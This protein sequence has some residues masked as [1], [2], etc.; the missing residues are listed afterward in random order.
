MSVINLWP[1]LAPFRKAGRGA[2]MTSYDN[3]FVPIADGWIARLQLNL[4]LLI[5][6]CVRYL[7]IQLS[8]WSSQW[9]LPYFS[10][11][12]IL[13]KLFNFTTEMFLT[14]RIFVFVDWDVLDLHCQNFYPPQWRRE[15]P[16]RFFFQMKQSTNIHDLGVLAFLTI[17][18]TVFRG[19][20]RYSIFQLHNLCI[21]C[22]TVCSLCKLAVL[23]KCSPF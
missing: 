12:Q 11:M 5:G 16:S 9:Q 7:H 1:I 21:S 15:H 2:W 3:Q 14:C 10:P 22:F 13:F 18:C 4:T 17:W 20:F 6:V 19:S 8:P 23:C